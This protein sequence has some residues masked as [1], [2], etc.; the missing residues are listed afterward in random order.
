MYIIARHYSNE[1][2]SVFDSVTIEHTLIRDLKEAVENAKQL[3]NDNRDEDRDAGNLVPITTCDVYEFDGAPVVFGT[4]EYE[5]ED[6]TAYHLVYAVIEVS[7]Q[8]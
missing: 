1:E 7:E 4:G 6:Y 2:D 8:S 5:E 3:F